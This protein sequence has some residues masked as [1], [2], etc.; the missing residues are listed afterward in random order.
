M[1]CNTHLSLETFFRVSSVGD[2]PNETIA[3]DNGIRALDDV[4]IALLFA[5]LVVSVLVVAHVESELV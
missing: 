5:I 1:A 3:V 4:T 2:G